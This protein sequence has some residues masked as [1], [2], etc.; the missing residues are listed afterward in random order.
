MYVY[1]YI[2]TDNMKKFD[3][4]LLNLIH[5]GWQSNLPIWK[6]IQIK[7]KEDTCI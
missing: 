3:W 2:E 1:Q 4:S 6:H 7:C 5:W